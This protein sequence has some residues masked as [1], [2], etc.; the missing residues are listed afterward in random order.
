MAEPLFETRTMQ[1]RAGTTHAV[2]LDVAVPADAVPGAYRGAMRFEA[3]G[4]TLEVPFELSVHKTV[5]PE[6]PL[7]EST[8]WLVP[9]PENLTTRANAPAW[10]SEEHW[11]LLEN[12]GRTLRD[13]GQT[14]LFT[15]VITGEH[16]LID[17]TLKPDGTYVFGFDR[18][19]RWCETFLAMG[20]TKIEGK[21]VTWPGTWGRV[22]ATDEA[23]GEY[24]PIIEKMREPDCPGAYA[25][26]DA[27]YRAL[28]AHLEQKGWVEHY[29]QHQPTD[30]A[31]MHSPTSRKP[32]LTHILTP[33]HAQFLCDLSH[34]IPN[35]RR[36]T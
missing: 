6:T 26:L 31:V 22:W 30:L 17:V 27:C 10:W 21:H 29:M 19:D 11:T 13:F 15:P 7:L 34:P 14:A 20:F 12:V 4:R 9:F 23:K 3:G 1:L 35:E 8:H 18:F 32:H 16:Q 2:L 5:A 25:F 24:R 28:Y 36:R 33:F